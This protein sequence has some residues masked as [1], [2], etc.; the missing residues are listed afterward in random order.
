[1]GNF[2]FILLLILFYI[3]LNA[4]LFHWLLLICCNF[5]KK[6]YLIAINRICDVVWCKIQ[7]Q[8]DN[9]VLNLNN[10]VFLLVWNQITMFACMYVWNKYIYSYTYD[11]HR[12]THVH[13]LCYNICMLQHFTAV[14]GYCNRCWNMMMKLCLSISFTQILL[15]FCSLVG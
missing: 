6:K 8:H 7:K 13:S 5:N 1:M 10:L 15:T 12:H 9:I 3:H 4:I 2:F 14:V 11:V